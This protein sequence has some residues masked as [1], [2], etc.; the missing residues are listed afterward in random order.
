MVY[1]LFAHS[2]GG[3]FD[4]IMLKLHF[5][6]ILYR[7]GVQRSFLGD[8]FFL[9]SPFP[10]P[11]YRNP[12]LFD[13]TTRYHLEAFLAFLLHTCKIPT[14]ALESGWSLP[15]RPG[16]RLT[17]CVNIAIASATRPCECQV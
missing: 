6:G 17:A 16:Q 13:S 14:Q 3:L 1:V 4:R 11:A 12:S 8:H 5:A 2:I 10:Q 7:K 9:P 15:D